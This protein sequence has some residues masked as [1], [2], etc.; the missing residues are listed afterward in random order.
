[1]LRL[2]L[3]WKSLCPV[4]FRFKTS[5]P[6]TSVAANNDNYK[7]NADSEKKK[8]PVLY[9]TD[10]DLQIRET[11]N[12]NVMYINNDTGKKSGTSNPSMLTEIDWDVEMAK[13]RETENHNPFAINKDFEG[14]S[15]FLGPSFNLAAYVTKSELLQQMLKLGVSIYHWERMQDVHSWILKKDFNM[16][17]QPVIQF[18]V[19]KGVSPDSLGRIFTKNPFIFNTTPEER[20]IRN[21]YLLHKKFDKETIANIYTKNPFWLVFRLIKKY[22]KYWDYNSFS[23]NL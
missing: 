1:M 19:D 2:V 7:N 23:I 8:L 6:D 16:D 9:Y 13:I 5:L 3:Q 15:S 10:S 11:E 20:E 12:N 14:V 4:T 21:N 18:L 22:S 17:V